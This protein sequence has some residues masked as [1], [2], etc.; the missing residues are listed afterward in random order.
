M[1]QQQLKKLQNNNSLI[2][3]YNELPSQNPNE[4]QDLYFDLNKKVLNMINDIEE[5]HLVKTQKL[6]ELIE[7]IQD[8]YSANIA[9]KLQPNNM[10][11]IGNKL[12]FNDHNSSY[13]TEI[14]NIPLKFEDPN[15]FISKSDERGEFIMKDE[16]S[17]YEL[18]KSI[19]DN[20][21]GLRQETKK[22]ILDMKGELKSDISKMGTKMDKADENIV[23][24]KRDLAVIAAVNSEKNINKKNWVDRFWIVASILVVFLVDKFTR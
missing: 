18:I 10:E 19:N 22:D 15:T 5:K 24:I 11:M 7:I 20:L 2:E 4:L 9:E 14:T 23:V 17:I 21:D 16:V 6:K 12:I 1:E 3:S 8:D 13:S